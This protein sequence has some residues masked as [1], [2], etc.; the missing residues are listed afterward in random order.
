MSEWKT[1]KR[2]MVIP[3]MDESSLKKIE[4]KVCGNKFVPR[5]E[6]RYVVKDRMATGGINSAFSGQYSEPKQY[7]A[8]DCAVCGCQLIVKERLKQIDEVT[9]F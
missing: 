9:D 6:N 3:G 5:N 1:R 2:K 7:D 4:C 8:F